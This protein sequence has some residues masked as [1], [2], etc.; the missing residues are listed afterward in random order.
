MQEKETKFTKICF[1]F[2][3]IVSLDNQIEMIIGFYLLTHVT[4]LLVQT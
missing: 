1:M 3:R 4:E 2:Y